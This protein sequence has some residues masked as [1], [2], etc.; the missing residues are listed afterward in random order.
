MQQIAVLCAH[1]GKGFL[2]EENG[3]RYR[4]WV[5]GMYWILTKKQH[6]SPVNIISLRKFSYTLK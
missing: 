3:P 6:Q 4:Q 2:G 5:A 1:R